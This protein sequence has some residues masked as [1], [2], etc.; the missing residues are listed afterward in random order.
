[1]RSA[2]I[3][4]LFATLA[5][6]AADPRK[7][8]GRST[9]DTLRE[10]LSNI[11]RLKGTFEELFPIEHH[12]IA[13]RFPEFNRRV[14]ELFHDRPSHLVALNRGNPVVAGMPMADFYRSINRFAWSIGDTLEFYATH[15]IPEND[16]ARTIIAKYITEF[17][18]FTAKENEPGVLD[19]TNQKQLDTLTAYGKDV[20]CANWA[21]LR[22]SLRIGRLSRV[23]VK[24][25]E[26]IAEGVLTD[27]SELTKYRRQEIDHFWFPNYAPTLAEQ[28][29]YHQVDGRFWL[30]RLDYQPQSIAFGETKVFDS[31]FNGSHNAKTDVY[32]QFD[33]YLDIASLAGAQW[34]LPPEVYYFFVAGITKGQIDRMQRIADAFNKNIKDMHKRWPV[35][36]TVYGDY[37]SPPVTMPAPLVAP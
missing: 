5:W 30:P 7:S 19:P 6:G 12:S 20:V 21:E 36:V 29:Q 8:C 24:V 22:L 33:R 37:N 14:L 3:I 4:F 31:P 28:D 18:K 17:K 26:L 15:L 32:E 35:K 34:R 11:H 25:H 10:N 13:Q 1:M 9:V 23:S 16:H 2:V 27:D